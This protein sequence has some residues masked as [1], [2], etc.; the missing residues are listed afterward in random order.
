M[1]YYSLSFYRYRG[2]ANLWFIG[3][4]YRLFLVQVFSAKLIRG[5]I[6]QAMFILTCSFCR[7]MQRIMLEGYFESVL[8]TVDSRSLVEVLRLQILS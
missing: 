6:K 7:L 3:P 2:V 4:W 5:T 8:S 1:K